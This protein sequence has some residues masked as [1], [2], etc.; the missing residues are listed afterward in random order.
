VKGKKV[1]AKVAKYHMLGML[2][3]DSFLNDPKF[4][5]VTGELM[6]ERNKKQKD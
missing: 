1:S 3:H 4:Q 5:Q 6:K 2:Q